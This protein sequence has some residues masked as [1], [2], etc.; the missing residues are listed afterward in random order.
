MREDSNNDGGIKWGAGIAVDGKRPEWL[1]DDDVI[2]V[3]NEHGTYWSDGVYK[4]R[5]CCNWPPQTHIRLPANHPYYLAT[6]RGFTYWPGGESA[7][8][9]WDGANILRR[10][11]KEQNGVARWSW[12][13]PHKPL[14]DVI[15]YRKRTEQP[16]PAI[17]PALVERMLAL[18]KTIT[19]SKSP[20]SVF[21]DAW[22]EEAE[23]IAKSMDGDPVAMFQTENPE[24]PH[25]DRKRLIEAALRW[26]K[27][28]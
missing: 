17:A 15:G 3:I 23:Q 10:D 16:A 21:A 2:A 20:R 6:S 24:W 5:D 27:E 4:A 25:L 14:A 28:A 11:G 13:G 8:D 26:G 12:N 7:P 19:S 1:R 22:F 9:D 18:V